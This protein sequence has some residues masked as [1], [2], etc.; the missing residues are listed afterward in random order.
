MLIHDTILPRARVLQTT[1]LLLLAG[2]LAACVVPEA[3]AAPS[4]VKPATVEGALDKPAVREVVRAHIDE[5]R[6]CYNA[7]LVE[8]ETVAGRS[9]I[10][11]VIQPDGSVSET[12][13]RESTMPE[14]F[15]ACMVAAVEGWSFPTADAETRVSYP[16]E[17]SPG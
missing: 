14:R 4:T 6:E 10:A 8:D 9:V 7:E 1:K 11:F 5:V 3:S 17:M 16:F 15:D 12:S 13:V 2:L